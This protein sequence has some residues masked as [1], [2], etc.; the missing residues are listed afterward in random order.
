MRKKTTSIFI[1]YIFFLI[2]GNLHGL[3]EKTI[4]IGAGATWKVVENRVGITELSSVR[5]NPVLALSSAFLPIASDA[6]DMVLSFDE[7]R[8][9]LFTDRIGHYRVSVFPGISAA[10]RFLARAGTGAALFSGLET[11]ATDSEVHGIIQ[12]LGNR[13]P[14]SGPL[15]LTPGRDALLSPDRTLGDFSLEFWLYPAN[16]VTGEQILLWTSSLKHNRGDYTQQLIQCAVFRNR[17]QWTF[18]DFF[19]PPAE[20][21]RITIV[22]NGSTPLVPK[23]WTHHLIRFDSDTGLL[24]Y[25]VNG[26]LEEIVYVTSSGREG[27]QVYNPVI[28]EEGSMVLGGRF[29]GL[30]DEFKLYSRCIPDPVTKKYPSLGGRMET[31]PID[32]GEGNSTVLMVD[33]SGGRTSSSGGAMLNEYAGNGGFHFS[34]DAALQFFI[35]A[36]DSPYRWTEADWQP[37]VPGTELSG[38]RGRFVQVAAVFYPSRDGETTPYL[39]A[40][41]IVYRPDEPPRSPPMVTAIARDGV[42]DLSWKNSLDG[43][44]AG[45]LVYY[46]TAGGEYFGEGAILGVSPIDVG[47]RTAV[48]IDGLQN[49]TLY[50]FVVAAYDRRDP[51]HVGEFSREVTARP[52]RM[53]E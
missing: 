23:T 43:D 29:V 38:V 24:E 46:G 31:R 42:V 34:D 51:F 12:D 9:D 2:S 44:V 18:S 15:I 39:D 40:I 37:L 10:N 27:G 17:L 14:H 16:M 13:G 41:Q 7:Q 53:V 25:L 3:G 5:P 30:L 19:S 22:L 20:E 52:L 1:V 36:A 11:R 28:G 48:H 32:L 50:Y 8:P 49:G 33:V 45:Y 35:R 6:L 26:H 4:L 47:K 21:R